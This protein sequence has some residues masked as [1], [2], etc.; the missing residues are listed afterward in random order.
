MTM[1][2]WFSQHRKLQATIRDLRQRLD[3]SDDGYTALH[4]AVGEAEVRVSKM[5]KLR[6]NDGMNQEGLDIAHAVE[7]LIYKGVY[8]GRDGF[9]A[10]VQIMVRNAL[11][12]QA[13]GF[14]D[15]DSSV[16]SV[17]KP[18]QQ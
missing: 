3:E 17:K 10:K 1:F 7:D 4:Q 6:S 13:Q 16:D 9:I 2:G 15:W 14:V 12:E 18:I 8:H 5:E 11:Q